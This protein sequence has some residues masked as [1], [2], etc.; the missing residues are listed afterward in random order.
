M[1]PN[2]PGWSQ[3]I[4]SQVIP[5]L[6]RVVLPDAYPQ[7]PILR[8]LFLD[9]SS[10][11]PAPRCLL[12]CLIICR[13][14]GKPRNWLRTPRRSSCITSWPLSSS[15]MTACRCCSTGCSH[16]TS[17]GTISQLVPRCPIREMENYY[18]R[19]P[20]SL[21]S[22]FEIMLRQTFSKAACRHMIISGKS[23]ENHRKS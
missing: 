10:Q 11:M 15:S 19:K 22:A 6:P 18:W 23:Y 2:D 16:S 3:M 5:S 13:N 9:V 14:I 4:P 21:V 1:I 8:C 17:L 7:V 20:E 12:S